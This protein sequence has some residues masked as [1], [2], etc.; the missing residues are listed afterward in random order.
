MSTVRREKAD[1]M[2]QLLVTAGALSLLALSGPAMAQSKSA[3]DSDALRAGFETPPN[4]ARPRVWWHWMNGNVTL[5]GAKLDLAW[6]RRIGIGGVHTFSGGGLGGKPIVP[7]PLPFMSPGWRDVFRQTTQIA[8]DAGMEV[9]VAGSPGWSQTGGV[10]VEPRDA[11][12]KYVWS[13]TQI[14]GGR[15]FDG[16]LSAPPTTPGPFQGVR[17]E[18]RGGGPVELKDEAYGDS[19]VIA[20]PT[21]LAESA[22]IKSTITSSAGPL[23]LTPITG[24]ALTGAVSVPFVEGGKS[25][26]VQVSYDQPTS[27]SAITLGSKKPA[28]VEILVSDTGRDFRSLVR[29]PP[30][31]AEHPAPQRT[32]AFAPTSGRVFRIMLTA[33]P[34]ARPLPGAPAFLFGPPTTAKGFDLTRLSFERGARVDRFEAKAGFQSTL[35]DAEEAASSANAARPGAIFAGDVIDLTSR[36]GPDGRLAWTPPAGAWTVLRFGWS[37]TGATNGPAEPEATG[38]E[39]DKLDAAAVGRYI[40]AYLKLYDEAT[41]GKL[42]A[43]GVENLLTDS[44]EAGTQNWT[45]GLLQAFRDRRGYDPTPFLPVLA[46][47]VVDTSEVSDRFLWDY[48]QTLKDLLVDN[49]YTVLAKALHARGMGYYSEAQGDTPRAIGDGMTMKSRADIPTAEYWYRPFA[50]APGQPPLKADLLEAASVA[51]VYGRPF[52]AAESLTVAASEDMWGFSP[53]MLKPVAD[54][55]FAHGVN[56]ILMHESHQQPIVD[57]KPGLAMAFFGQFFNRNDTWAE[58]AGPWID[59]LSRTSYLLQRGYDVSDVAYFYGEDK[60][61]TELFHTRFNT[62]VPDGYR[63]DYI[64]PD[65]LRTQLKVQDG[66]LVSQGGARYRVLYMPSH[67]TRLTLPTLRKLAALVADGAVLVGAKPISGLGMEASDAQV[68]PL[69]DQIWGAQPG[70]AVRSYGRGRVYGGSDL[71][72]ALA[73]EKIAP[74]I[75]YE[76][77]AADARILGLH[78]RDTDGDIYFISNQRDRG[79]RFEASFRVKGKVPELWNAQTGAV[80][81]LSYRLDGDRVSV[82][83]SLGASD[84]V[85]VV[86][87]KP[88]TAESWRAPKVVETTLGEIKGAWTLD[89][90]TGRGAPASATFD[91]LIDWTAA[92]ETG[93][94]Y[95][96]GAATYHKRID[97]PRAWFVKGQRLSLNLGDVRDL[98]VVTVNGKVLPTLWRGPYK[99]DV[100]EALKPGRNDISI[101][102]VNLWPNRLIGDKQPG[103]KPV[104]F[105][106]VNFY[107]ATTP[108]RSSGLLGPVTIEA[109]K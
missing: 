105:A 79:E 109:E 98:A 78:R 89:F 104:A 33:P 1:R 107:Q 51:H 41:G 26:W 5:E 86:F 55:I 16:V 8:H 74:D 30:D 95:F 38:L 20:F 18:R 60:N 44:W 40:D 63:Y 21:P 35:G 59:Y 96:S 3:P 11:M 94:K 7:E 81:P 62:D 87:R 47:R 93:I 103:A 84:A 49:H 58:Q 23:D 61:L 14:L 70:F 28:M 36:M 65:G 102:V 85:F 42:G 12:K 15:P 83:M 27:L 4:A 13:E 32:Y 50:T 69:V 37:L 68:Q 75:V 10:W 43:S 64:N 97:A 9:S 76:G 77:R 6:M 39:V 88:A 71:S 100:T 72:V 34:P 82:P 22:T 46:G 45:P 73:A 25:A 53:A 17:K 106:P 56:R 57:G 2:R 48:R 92:S 31:E 19:L 91:N 52:V 54:E 67:V 99:A 80:T 29:V 108:L 24:S 66:R 101:K 90:E